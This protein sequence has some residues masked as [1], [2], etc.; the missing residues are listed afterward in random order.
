MDVMPRFSLHL[1]TGLAL[2][3]S[4]SAG[5]G[6]YYPPPQSA[7]TWRSYVTPNQT[8]TPTE[9]ATLLSERGVD[10]SLL[11]QAWQGLQVSAQNGDMELL[12][13]KDGWIVGHWETTP[14]LDLHRA[15]I[16]KTFTSMTLAKMFD[17]SDAGDFSGLTP[18]TIG[19]E[20]VAGDYLPASWLQGDP[21]RNDL[22]VKHML[23]MS[24]GITVS[25]FPTPSGP[26]LQTVLGLGTV[27][28]PGT[29]W[30]YASAPVDLLSI[31][32]RDW[33]GDYLR[34][35]FLDEIGTPIGMEPITW[36]AMGDAQNGFYT[37]GSAYLY[38]S[39]LELARPAYLLLRD[40]VWDDGTGPETILSPARVALLS[41]PAP[42]LASTTIDPIS[43]FATTPNSNLTYG[44]L[45]WTND[46]HKGWLAESVPDDAYFM[47]GFGTRYVMIVPSLDLVVV[48][49]AERPQPWSY[50]VVIAETELL[51]EALGRTVEFP[52]FCDAADGALDACP[53]GN[54][55][56][57]ITGCDI[58]QGTGGVQLDVVAQTTA[59]SNG[60]TLT[61]SGFPSG[62]NPTAIVIRGV[63]LEAS[64]A[65]FGDG[66]R[67]VSVPLVRL[68]AAF[69]Q[70]GTSQHTF[71]HG[72]MAG[73][74]VR[75][76]QLWFRNTPAMFCTPDAFNLSNGREIVW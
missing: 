59:P 18:S 43:A 23:T 70:A 15:S 29:S 68:G 48:R 33:T 73:T 28:D 47:A 58:Q 74:G 65:P 42:F 27:A 50:G 45:T 10:W 51:M 31:I 49:Y 39:A 11:Q 69:A 8:P 54:A 75:T 3:A 55:G 67:C 72:T 21:R 36:S 22:R 13:I 19:P 25:D 61:G 57:P 35:M 4:A 26:Y 24:S 30:A 46:D 14:S 37:V 71:G 20:S 44:H 41:Q 32:V 53:C 1:L 56:Y 62:A 40:G 17:M 2:A 9:Q 63:G 7:G 60:V 64:P 52:S 38:I 34:D 6:G 12:V 76:Y 66:L 5:G 16:A